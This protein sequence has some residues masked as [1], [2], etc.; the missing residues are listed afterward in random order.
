M[1]RTSSVLKGT[2]RRQLSTTN[3]FE[4][5]DMKDIVLHHCYRSRSV[6]PLWAMEELGLPYRVVSLAF[7]PRVF[8]K[9]YKKINPMGTV[10]HLYDPNTGAQ[11]T[12]SSA[13]CHYLGEMY[14][15]RIGSRWQDCIVRPSEVD[16]GIFIDWM[17]RSDATLTFP[18]TLYLRYGVHEPDDRKQ[19]QVAEDYETWF[20]ARARF[21]EASLRDR[22][23]LVADRFTI[24]DIAV[25]YALLLAEDNDVDVFTPNI[26]LYWK[27]LKQRPA[28]IV[29]SEL[30]KGTWGSFPRTR[31][32]A[33]ATGVSRSGNSDV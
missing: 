10:P 28:F 16:Y 2:W 13:M 21:L 15:D 31:S 4:Y 30:G 17:Y 11:M 1:I 5:R 7:P 14:S 24:A 32:D 27:R 12:E 29:A 20:L 26:D 6:R 22:E 33:A 18:Q 8:D 9:G 23:F 3:D 25:G 19:P